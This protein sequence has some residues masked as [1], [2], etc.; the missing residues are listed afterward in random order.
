MLLR[1][2]GIPR[3]VLKFITYPTRFDNRETE[4][5]LKGSGSACLRWTTT[6]GGCGTT[7]SATSTR[8]CSSTAALK[9]QGRRQGG[10]DH[11]RLLRHRPAAALKRAAAGRQDG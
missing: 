4:R 9:G 5:A 10:A 1:D 6:R 2:L 8:T 3:E 11:R 7:G